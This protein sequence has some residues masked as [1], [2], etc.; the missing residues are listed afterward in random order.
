MSLPPARTVLF[1][2]IV[3][4]APTF[5]SVSLFSFGVACGV[6]GA[7]AITALAVGKIAG[8]EAGRRIPRWAQRYGQ[9][10]QLVS[11][12]LTIV[13]TIASLVYLKG[14]ESIDEA[15]AFWFVFVLFLTGSIVCRSLVGAGYERSWVWV[16]RNED[17]VR[18]WSSRM[19]LTLST[20]AAVYALFG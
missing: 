14:T 9:I 19:H 16:I 2:A 5:L 15:H 8:G 18:T 20:V 11:G 10:I 3:M 17:A 13:M 4:A 7:L 1:E 6:C 12:S